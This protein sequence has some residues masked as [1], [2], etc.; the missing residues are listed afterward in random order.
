VLSNGNWATT[1]VKP[2]LAMEANKA[3]L[4]TQ[5]RLAAQR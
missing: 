1:G 2:D 4:R 3:L 5:D